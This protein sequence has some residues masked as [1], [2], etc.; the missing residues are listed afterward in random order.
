MVTCLLYEQLQLLIHWSFVIRYTTWFGYW[1]HLPPPARSQSTLERDWKW[2]FVE[3]TLYKWIMVIFLIISNSVLDNR[4][5]FKDLYRSATHIDPCV[6]SSV[7]TSQKHISA[8][9]KTCRSSMSVH[10]TA[11]GPSPSALNPSVP[12]KLT[13]WYSLTWP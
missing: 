2:H 9:T 8:F 4:R 3:K 11:G 1:R 6:W 7:N 10:Q 12:D 5:S 13:H